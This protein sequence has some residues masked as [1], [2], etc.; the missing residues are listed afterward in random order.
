MARGA[1]CAGAL[2]AALWLV[3]VGNCDG[4]MFYLHPGHVQCF[5]EDVRPGK[6]LK[7]EVTIIPD[8]A[9]VGRM[10]ID[11]WVTKL[12]DGYRKD[13]LLYKKDVDHAVFTVK[14]PTIP[15]S[16]EREHYE[17]QV[18]VQHDMVKDKFHFNTRRNINLSLRKEGDRPVHPSIDGGP[19]ETFTMAM[20]EGTDLGVE[21]MEEIASMTK[22][23]RRLLRKAERIQ[24][25]LA[26]LN[27]ITCVIVLLTGLSN[28]FYT[29]RFIKREK[30]Y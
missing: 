23:S 28:Y 3:L 19:L 14:M 16:A 25:Q 18:C 6:S 1:G 5:E 8:P 29:V 7:G 9:A 27:A 24:G 2:V 15:F 11:V 26:K 17:V 22:S 10:D 21:I 13:V 4:I 12:Q 20:E 30:V